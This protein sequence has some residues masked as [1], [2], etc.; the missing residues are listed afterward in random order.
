MGKC[1]IP[2]NSL[3]MKRCLMKIWKIKWRMADDSDYS[4]FLASARVFLQGYG[5]H[6]IFIKP[7]CK[8]FEM[9]KKRRTISLLYSLSSLL[10]VDKFFVDEKI[11][12]NHFKH[13]TLRPSILQCISSFSLC[14]LDAQVKSLAVLDPSFVC[15]SLYE[16]VK[17]RKEYACDFMFKEDAALCFKQLDFIAN[18]NVT[19]NL[20]YF[21]R[22]LGSRSKIL[23]FKAF[24]AFNSVFQDVES[25][26]KCSGELEMLLLPPCISL[27]EEQGKPCLYLG[28]EPN[29]LVIEDP[30]NFLQFGFEFL[31]ER[32]RI[33]ASVE[34]HKTDARNSVIALNAILNKYA[35]AALVLDE[36]RIEEI[37]LCCR[38]YV[39]DEPEEYGSIQ[40]FDFLFKQRSLKD[41]C[42]CYEF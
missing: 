26:L 22:F 2:E 15:K 30:A 35:E 27:K 19:Y 29:S 11:V 42:D 25:R 7:I 5:D 6:T 9:R 37:G 31:E 12:I 16:L 38:K 39:P 32:A 40:D 33:L 20:K 34:L 10:R 1:A 8:G 24:E 41:A 17:G 3:A 13:R 23:A 21:I 36:S 4:M 14:A 18:C 28:I